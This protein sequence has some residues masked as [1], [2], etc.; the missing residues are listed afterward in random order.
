MKKIFIIFSLLTYY[1]AS[2]AT[3]FRC[4]NNL[5]INN[6]TNTATF[7]RNFSEAYAVANSGDTIIVEPSPKNYSYVY[8]A[9]GNHVGYFDG[10]ISKS[11]TIVGNGYWTNSSQQVNTLNSNFVG[12]VLNAP[13]TTLYGLTL[14]QSLRINSNNLTIQRCYLEGIS[15]YDQNT[16]NTIIKENFILNGIGL[17][18][19]DNIGVIISNNILRWYGMAFNST[20]VVI[21]E[22]NIIG[23]Y[24]VGWNDTN[25][26][27][28]NC[29]AVFRNN[30][31]RRDILNF[32]NATIENNIVLGTGNMP[33]GNGNITGAVDTD[34][35]Q[36]TDF[37]NG[38][39]VTFKLKT[40][41]ANP[42]PALNAGYYGNG[43]DIGAYNDGTNRPSYRDGGIPP[44]PTIYQLS[45]GAV[46]GNSLNVT[47]STRAN[48]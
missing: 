28:G 14:S 29:N 24:D 23:A 15:N 6:N 21:I 4:N 2:Y 20:D 42:N 16:A 45:T 1:V 32:S 46:N 19:Y 37:A 9:A 5:G 8:D 27:F 41:G 12:L 26:N 33:S 30:I 39:D 40:N 31:K 22:N 3:T 34:I 43:D 48:N 17:N 36:G 13:N 44:F 10:W 47:I 25:V 18:N 7:Y 11:L 38:T 35:F